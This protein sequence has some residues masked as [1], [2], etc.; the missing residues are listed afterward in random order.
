[1]VSC[2]LFLYARC[3]AN[4]ITQGVVII[5]RYWLRQKADTFIASSESTTDEELEAFDPK[6]QEMQPVYTLAPP[7]MQSNV[8]TPEYGMSVGAVQLFPTHPMM[9]TNTAQDPLATLSPVYTGTNVRTAY[10]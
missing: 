10:Y 5:R 4:L 6:T 7:V 2:C 3:S 1:M 9:Q 8:M